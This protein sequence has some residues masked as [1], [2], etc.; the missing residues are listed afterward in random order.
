MIQCFKDLQNSADLL[1]PL[2]N[3]MSIGMV[4]K[5]ACSAAGKETID[6]QDALM[7]SIVKYFSHVLEYRDEPTS[8]LFLQNLVPDLSIIAGGIIQL[9]AALPWFLEGVWQD[10]SRGK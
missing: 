1:S 6:C 9:S 4:S 7:A 5:Q 2:R 3:K 10:R 8:E